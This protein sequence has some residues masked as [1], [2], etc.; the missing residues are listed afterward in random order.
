MKKKKGPR[1]NVI[2]ECIFCRE[3]LKNNKNG[4]SR[5]LTSKNRKNTPNK[6]QLNKYCFCCKKSTLHKE[7]K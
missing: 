6:L 2:L 5:Y 1:I 7:I 3:N 4:V